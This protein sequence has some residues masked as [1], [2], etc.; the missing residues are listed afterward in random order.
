MHFMEESQAFLRGIGS[1]EITHVSLFQEQYSEIGLPTVCAQYYK[2]DIINNRLLSWMDSES[3]P[4]WLLLCFI[5]LEGKIIYR[6]RSMY[7]AKIYKE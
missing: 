6:T 2:T 4:E 3:D 1:L 5:Q 7:Q